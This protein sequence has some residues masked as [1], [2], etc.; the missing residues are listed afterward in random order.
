MSHL[1]LVRLSCILFNFVDECVDEY[2]RF[3]VQRE[4]APGG[5]GVRSRTCCR[6][7]GQSP[8]ITP[9]LQG[10]TMSAVIMV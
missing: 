1:F 6:V 8:D 4:G 9:S 3:K 2:Q 7:G 5:S 10:N